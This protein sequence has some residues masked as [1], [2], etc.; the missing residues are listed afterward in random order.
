MKI[1]YNGNTYYTTTDSYGFDT[2]L[3]I[4]SKISVTCKYNNYVPETT[5]YSPYIF[6]QPNRAYSDTIG[7]RIDN[8]KIGLQEDY[9]G[10][11]DS[12]YNSPTIV[13]NYIT[14]YN[15]ESSSGWKAAATEQ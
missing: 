13:Q 14:N 4:G 1:E 3:H 9:L 7:F 10:Y 2:P 12:T 8:L 15:F 5:D 11:I 6:I